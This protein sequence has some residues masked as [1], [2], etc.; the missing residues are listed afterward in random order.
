MSE[1]RKRVKRDHSD[2]QVTTSIVNKNPPEFS[3]QPRPKRL[4]SCA[5]C[6]KH[7]IKCDYSDTSPHPCSSCA[8]RGVTCEL[9][10]VIPVKRSNIIKRLAR[11]VDDLK[12][13]VDEMVDRESRLKRLCT[14]RHIEVKGLAD[15]AEPSVCLTPTESVV[16]CDFDCGEC[17]SEGS[18][19]SSTAST[20]SAASIGTCQSVGTSIS[21]VGSFSP[22]NLKFSGFTL[23]PVCSYSYD[24]VCDS[25]GKFNDEFLCYLPFISE[26]PSPVKVYQKSK[27]FFWTIIYA[28]SG[29]RQIADQLPSLLRT[30]PAIDTIQSLTILATFPT[31]DN[32]ISQAHANDTI[33][34]PYL[35]AL[36][37]SQCLQG[38]RVTSKHSTSDDPYIQQLHDLFELL[39]LTLRMRSNSR[40]SYITTTCTDTL[41]A[42]DCRGALQPVADVIRV[43]L[44]MNTPAHNSKERISTNVKVIHQ[45]CETFNSIAKLGN[46]QHAPA[47]I[48]TILEFITLVTVK[49]CFSPFNGG[50]PNIAFFEKLLGV[51]SKFNGFDDT[52]RILDTIGDLESNFKLDAAIVDF[53]KPASACNIDDLIDEIDKIT[54]AFKESRNEGDSIVLKEY[55]DD[56]SLNFSGYKSCCS[57]FKQSVVLGSKPGAFSEPYLIDSLALDTTDPYNLMLCDEPLLGDFI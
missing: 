26:L 57:L 30:L 54:S 6:R 8:K 49:M 56:N 33:Y 37:L 2:P 51:L 32:W 38:G 27:L 40:R 17:C 50:D 47:Y 5:R 46:L 28:V 20:V 1:R 42:M 43:V 52:K 11:D 22:E 14:E 24:E 15:L 13:L 23:G 31:Q 36:R 55:F 41:D 53:A 35:E 3:D 16:S 19:E 21:S 45:C 44:A 7:K 29:N 4:R 34:A 39:S 9:E 25:F 48:K 10:I 18:N 12:R